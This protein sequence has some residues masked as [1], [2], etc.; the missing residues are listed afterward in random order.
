MQT[1]RVMSFNIRGSRFDDGANR[2]PTRAELNV[3]TIARQRPDLIGFQELDKGNLALYRERLPHYEFLLGP[4]YNDA[5][6]F[7]YPTIAYDPQ[8]LAV[9]AHGEFWLSTTPERHSRAW[10]TA[11]IRSANWARFE[12]REAGL[13]LLHLNTHLDHISEQARVEGAR[14]IVA[15]LAQLAPPELPVIVTGDFNCRPGSE[16]YAA[17]AAAGYDDAFVL[18]GHKVGVNTFHGFEGGGFVSRDGAPLQIDWI[19]LRSGAAR[20]A[21]VGWRVIDDGEPPIYPSDH[22]PVVVDLRAER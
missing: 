8:R 14:L 1:L 11:C 20:L 3:A 21:P 15:R 5:E 6:P 17:F 22:Y 13:E 2:W 19:L 9:R 18:A 10:D 7:Q 16:A 12:W 4:P